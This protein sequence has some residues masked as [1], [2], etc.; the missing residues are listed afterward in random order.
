[1]TMPSTPPRIFLVGPMGAGK[2]TVGRRLAQTLR[3]DFVDSDHEIEQRAGAR[4]PLIFELEGEAGFRSRE[5]AIIAELTQR[6]AIVLATGGGAV[7]NADNR[8]CLV[9]RGFVV[10]LQASVDEQ[11]RRTRLDHNR[12]LLQTAD[13][14]TRLSQLIEQRD[15]LYREVADC[16]ISTEDQPIKQVVRAILHQLDGGDS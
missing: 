8:R 16:I 12:P 10:Y 2:T 5:K 4:I 6:P 3:Q 13:P 11:L 14:H 15:P 1:M 9:A 7:L